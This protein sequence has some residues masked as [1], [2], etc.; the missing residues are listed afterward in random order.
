MKQQEV[1]II[2]LCLTDRW[3]TAQVE[4]HH[5]AVGGQH[6][7]LSQL[8][9]LHGN[10]SSIPAVDRNEKPWRTSVINALHTVHTSYDWLIGYSSHANLPDINIYALVFTLLDGLEYSFYISPFGQS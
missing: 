3:I 10:F 5:Q 4:A 7:L 2:L 6:E 1:S 8:H 9:C